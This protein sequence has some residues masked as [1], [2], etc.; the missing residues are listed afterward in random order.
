M[1][2]G[3]RNIERLHLALLAAA[4]CVAFFS[5]WLAPISLLLGSAVMGVNFRLLSTL[6]GRL[7]SP[8]AAHNVGT[9]LALMLG[10]FALLVGL[11][12]LLLWRAPLEP[13]SF[14]A[15]ASLLLVAI[16][17]STLRAPVAA[18]AS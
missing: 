14:A 6:T 16:I 11:L 2:A 1:N 3:L 18:P 17:L 8:T 10:K 13:L 9:V 4:L 12:A 15:G 7:L 5:G